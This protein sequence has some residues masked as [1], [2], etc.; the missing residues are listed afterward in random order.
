[1]YE[2][3]VRPYEGRNY[4]DSFPIVTSANPKASYLAHKR[5][6][7]NAIQTVLTNGSYILGEQVKLFEAEFARYLGVKWA[8]GVGSGTD[9]LQL[10]L[11]ICD[12]GPGDSVLTVSHTAVATVSAIHLSGANPILVDIDPKAFTM[13][14]DLIEETLKAERQ[15][16]IKAI[17]PVH[18][19]GRPI[20]MHGVMDIAG[21]H[22]LYVIE[23]CAQAHGAQ[24][25]GQKVGSF[26]DVGAFSFYPTKNLGALGDGGALV[27]NDA[28][29]AEKAVM[30]RQY[31]WKQRYVS[32]IAGMNSRLDELQAAVLRIK[33]RSLD[34]ENTRR[35]N[36]ATMYDQGL[37]D[38]TFGV[39]NQPEGGLH[40]YYQ[41]AVRHPERDDFRAYL[42]QYGVET[43]VLYP[44]PVHLQP[45]YQ[46]H[47]VIGA[48]GLMETERVCREIVSL[49]MYPELADEQIRRVCD[50]S[51]EWD[52]TLH[53]T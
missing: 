13:R 27:T 37:P 34:E 17:I 52:R 51:L 5:D 28:Q 47:I 22:N 36:I 39:S 24:W 31:G 11:R 2:T 4:L 50:L 35:R 7:D 30:L 41:Y 44:Q 6:I 40:V 46:K 21:R 42:K 10:A 29:L 23:D 15:C 53:L 25:K 18:L 9:A 33:L 14:L 1:M 12:V 20:D 32:E 3:K 16:R 8:I 26:G 49:P 19:Y 48:G 43:A 45:G 38:A